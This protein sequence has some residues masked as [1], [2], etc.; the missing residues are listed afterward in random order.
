[1]D[2]E[3]GLSEDN[4]EETLIKKAMIH[5]S[6]QVVSMVTSSKL[7]TK[8]SF[9]VGDLDDLDTMITELDPKDDSLQPYSRKGIKLI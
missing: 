7:G 6:R 2:L 4:R 5:A 1:V 3:F 9:K 8:Q